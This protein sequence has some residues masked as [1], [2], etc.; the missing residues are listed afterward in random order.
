MRRGT[1]I[2]IGGLLALAGCGGGESSAG[3][4]TPST[5]EPASTTTSPA[6]LAAAFTAALGPIATDPKV[7]GPWTDGGSAYANAIVDYCS[8]IDAIGV[9]AATESFSKRAASLTAPHLGGSTDLA[10]RKM[11][12]EMMMELTQSDFR[13]AAR[14]VCP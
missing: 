3:D 4:D 2:V 9:E 1:V 11:R 8:D 7:P 6:E 14:E 12:A 10:D 13:D 5:T